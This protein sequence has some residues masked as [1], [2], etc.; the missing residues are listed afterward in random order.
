MIQG[1]PPKQGA[2]PIIE[3]QMADSSGNYDHAHCEA[4]VRLS[5]MVVREWNSYLEI[6]H[7]RNMPVDHSGKS[8]VNGVYH[9][10]MTNDAQCVK[11]TSDIAASSTGDCK[12]VRRFVGE[13]RDLRWLAD[14]DLFSALTDLMSQIAGSFTRS[15]RID[16][17]C[18]R[19]KGIQYLIIMYCDFGSS[20]IC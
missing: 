10:W 8:C 5:E 14:R 9:F 20:S 7:S 1:G 18:A 16:W 3:P 4:H 12:N 6:W 15:I 13:H 17:E 19:S 2:F 11:D